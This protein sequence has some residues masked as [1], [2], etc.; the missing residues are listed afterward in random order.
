MFESTKSNFAELFRF[1]SVE[2][3]LLQPRSGVFGFCV[4]LED[5][6]LSRVWCKR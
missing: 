6:L 4:F 5:F 1:P 2:T 3:D